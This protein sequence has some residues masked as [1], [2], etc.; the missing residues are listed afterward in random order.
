MYVEINELQDRFR[1]TNFIIDQD[2]NDAEMR[3]FMLGYK[4]CMDTMFE[5]ME[6]IKKNECN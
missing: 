3:G 6:D 2:L 1:K 5:M 4:K